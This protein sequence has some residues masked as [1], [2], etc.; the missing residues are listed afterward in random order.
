MKHFIYFVLFALIAGCSNPGGELIFIEPKE[1]D[2]F[3]FPYFLFIPDDVPTNGKTFVLI[4][5]N[6]S[7]FADDDLQKHIEKA[8]RTA[9]IDYYLGNYVA[10][11]L[12]CPL[13][14]PVF[15]RSK[16][17]WKMYT[18]ALDRDVMLQGEQPLKRID[19]QLIE[20]FKHAQ[21]VLNDKDIPSHNQFLLTGFSASG[22]FANRFTLLHPDRV[23]AVAAGGLNGLLMLPEDSLSREILNYPIGI[24]DMEELT[25]MAFQKDRFLKTPQFYFMGQLDENDAVPYDDAFSQAEREQI[26]KLLGEQMQPDRWNNCKQLY[27][28]LK[29]NADIRQYEGV[30]HKHPEEVKDDIVAFFSEVVLTTN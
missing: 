9:T 2:A 24:K 30:G 26:F 29:V 11:K 23:R 25:G 21:T 13:L 15:P 6:N 22:T 3:Q 7:G 12:N 4:E 20:M 19:L 14:V 1:T 5:P 28:D 17:N 27:E 8:E 16:T 18:H 10:R